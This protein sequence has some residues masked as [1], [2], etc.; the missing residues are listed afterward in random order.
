MRKD[1]H[2][3]EQNAFSC[4]KINRKL[5]KRRWRK[6]I[7]AQIDPR[8]FV[9]LV[10]CL[11]VIIHHHPSFQA[12]L[13]G[14]WEGG[15]RGGGEVADAHVEGRYRIVRVTDIVWQPDILDKCMCLQMRFPL[16]VE[17]TT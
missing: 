2:S 17:V 10:P 1:F 13:E 6:K 8:R 12:T 7:Y 15:G 4:K 16:F 9:R 3:I 14:V 5:Q 11:N